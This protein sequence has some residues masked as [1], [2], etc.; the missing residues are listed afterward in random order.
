MKINLFETLITFYTRPCFLNRC[1]G[2]P[3]HRL[4]LQINSP[5]RGQ[6]GGQSRHSFCIFPF[7]CTVLMANQFK[8]ACVPGQAGLV[9]ASL[10]SEWGS[11]GW[12]TTHTLGSASH[13]SLLHIP[14]FTLMAL[15]WH[16]PNKAL[17][18]YSDTT[19]KDWGSMV[20]N[21]KKCSLDSV[22]QL[23][24]F[25]EVALKL[26]SEKPEAVWVISWLKRRVI[27]VGSGQ[28]RACSRSPRK[29]SLRETQGERGKALGATWRS[30]QGNP[31]HGKD[32]R[33]SPSA[34]HE[35]GSQ[36]TNLRR[37]ES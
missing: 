32:F 13:P 18:Q 28:E 6:G 35:R 25:E 11:H 5:V 21:N 34:I 12:S 4:E 22:V 2:A 16:F 8:D 26:S 14:M 30:W 27:V 31:G 19:F 37:K 3:W 36:W 24:L 20:S 23:G 7:W 17:T 29:S 1:Q 33:F 15:V 10:H 9:A